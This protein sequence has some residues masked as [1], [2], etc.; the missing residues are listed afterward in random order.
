MNPTTDTRTR[1]KTSWRAAMVTNPS[2]PPI[3]GVTVEVAENS[4]IILADKEV[5]TGTSCHIYLDIPNTKSTQKNYIDFTGNVNSSAL[6]GQINMF[7]HLIQVKEISNVQ[8]DNLI[9]ALKAI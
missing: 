4:L 3:Y 6:I 2:V 8:R 5:K 7:R 1:K 9:K